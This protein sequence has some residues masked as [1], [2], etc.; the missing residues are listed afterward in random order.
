MRCSLD[1]ISEEESQKFSL[2]IFWIRA[3]LQ[4]FLA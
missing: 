2:Q 4:V 1:V 3:S